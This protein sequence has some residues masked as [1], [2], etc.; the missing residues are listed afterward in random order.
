M[1]IDSAYSSL[2][3]NSA[4][5]A[6]LLDVLIFKI[7]Q[8]PVVDRKVKTYPFTEQD[9][10]LLAWLVDMVFRCSIRLYGIFCKFSGHLMLFVTP[11]ER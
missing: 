10:V 9:R 5:P 1:R 3:D 6:D 2:S 11:T 8:S 7:K 4:S